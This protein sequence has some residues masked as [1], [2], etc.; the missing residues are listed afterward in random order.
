MNNDP[1]VVNGAWTAAEDAELD[2]LVY[3]LVDA[4]WEHRE[5]CADCKPGPCPEYEAWRTHEASCG[6]CEGS[7]PLTFGPPCR[8][9]RERRLEHGRTCPR[10][11]PCAHLK[12]A[13]REVG[14]WREARILLSRAQALR[15]EQEGRAA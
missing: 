13:I 15:A 8:D 1:P 11:N 5:H 2:V 12:T 4:F 6:A 7:A 10:C 3:V 14:E 9:W